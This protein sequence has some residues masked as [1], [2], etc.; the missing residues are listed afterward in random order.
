MI[1]FVGYSGIV[2]LNTYV[3]DPI[4]CI[5]HGKESWNDDDGDYL[6]WFCYIH[7]TE[8]LKYPRM[9][10]VHPTVGVF[11]CV[12]KTGHEVEGSDCVE[13]HAHYMWV[14]MVVLIQAGISY[15][16]RYFWHGWEG[17]RMKQKLTNLIEHPDFLGDKKG[18][19]ECKLSGSVELT[20]DVLM[21]S[22]NPHTAEL[23]S[24][25]LDSIGDNAYYALKYSLAEWLCLLVCFVQFSLT[26]KFLNGSFA[27]YGSA[28]MHEINM[29]PDNMLDPMQ[30]TLPIVTTCT[31][32]KFG[33][34][35]HRETTQA[36]CVLPNNI[37]HQKFYLFLW[38]W[39]IFITIVTSINQVY[40]LALFFIPGFRAYITKTFWTGRSFHI[41]CQVNTK[42]YFS[43]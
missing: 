43:D 3:G 25:Y 24:N 40:R 21:P 17:G 18:D 32:P 35:G 33:Q 41:K 1:I 8:S 38:F 4:D 19:R 6:D 34:A 26:D 2:T 42:S 7:G 30:R 5:H 37:V 11:G 12:N 16:P 20:A 10:S 39:L 28:V 23:A 27:T 31:L 36:I 15:L 9:G 14:S 13:T 29:D 22:E